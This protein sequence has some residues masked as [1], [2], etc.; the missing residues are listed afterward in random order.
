MG[1]Q[2]DLGDPS[3]SSTKLREKNERGRGGTPGTGRPTTEP[4]PQA[5]GLVKTTMENLQEDNP[6]R[7]MSTQGRR[8]DVRGIIHREIQLGW[9][10]SRVIQKLRQKSQLGWHLLSTIY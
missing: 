7:K 2:Q 4:I 3:D 1:L 9:H 10:L 5:R 8:G 6:M